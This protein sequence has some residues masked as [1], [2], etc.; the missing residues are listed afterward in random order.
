IGGGTR[1]KIYESMAAGVAVVS[2]TI[3]AEGLEIHPPA[4]LRIADDPDAFAEQC[5]ALLEN[6]KARRAV[7]RAGLELVRSRFSWDK[8]VDRF[9]EAAGMR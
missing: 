1:L 9:E 3:G 7:A 6:G 5:V 2:T 8:V 4:D